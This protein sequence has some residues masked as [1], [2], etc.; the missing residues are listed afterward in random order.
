MTLTR[1][2][3]TIAVLELVVEKLKT[4]VKTKSAQVMDSRDTEA[5]EN[6][7][8]D[9]MYIV[10]SRLKWSGR[11]WN[12]DLR[13]PCSILGHKHE[14]SSDDVFFSM[15]PKDRQENS[16]GRICKT[17]FKPGGECLVK[18]MKC[19]GKVPSNLL[20]PGCVAFTNRKKYLPHNVLIC[21]SKHPSHTK[22]ARGDL[23]AAL[24][25]YFGCPLGQNVSVD[26]VSSGTFICTQN[27][28]QTDNWREC[29]T[30]NTRAGSLFET[31]YLT[32]RIQVG[33]EPQLVMY[34]RGSNTNLIA[35]KIAE[36]ENM[37]IISNKPGK[38]KVAG[39]QSISTKYG[40]YSAVL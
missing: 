33:S 35:G 9:H 32:Q 7:Q 38:V 3:N 4:K 39:R 24:Q 31:V 8:V 36:T 10:D 5:G 27:S 25:K 21:N 28:S 17:G 19:G 20:C 18:N 37:E 1:L 23:I 11:W 12:R 34:D 15:S 22:P 26:Q 40:V 6:Q 14:L 2:K 16:R 29:I 13:F 30:T